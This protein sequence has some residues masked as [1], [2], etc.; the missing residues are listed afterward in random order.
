M[1]NE[2]VVHS[3]IPLA[4]FKAILGLDDRDDC[5][6]FAFV[7]NP[8]HEF[9]H[10]KNSANS[11]QPPSLAAF[12]LITA[13]YTI[14]HYCKRRLL[15]K[16]YFERIE[17]SDDPLLPLRE[18]PVREIL[19]VY[20]LSDMAAS[21]E[22]VEPDLYRLIPDLEEETGEEPEDTVYSLSLSPALFRRR[23]LAAVKAV[24]R[25]GYAPGKAGDPYG[26]PA[27]LPYSPPQSFGF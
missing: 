4:V 27:D 18:Y 5:L 11:F 7:Q 19:A 1:D 12:C 24:Y 25:A 6:D 13:T 22:P 10:G 3:L 23:C 17:V 14:E 9:L 26:A 20:S 21:G 16:R 8:G 2:P 15:L